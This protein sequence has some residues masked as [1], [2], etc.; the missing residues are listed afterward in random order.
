MYME[1]NNSEIITI[2]FNEIKEIRLKIKN[3]IKKI[4]EIKAVIKRII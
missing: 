3:K 4:E 1:E 2:R